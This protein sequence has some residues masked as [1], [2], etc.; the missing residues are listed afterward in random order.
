MHLRVALEAETLAV[1]PQLCELDRQL[2]LLCGDVAEPVAQRL[3]LFVDGAR[4]HPE[5][6]H[7]AVACARR[8]AAEPLRVRTAGLLSVERLHSELEI[9]DGLEL[10]AHARG[11]GRLTLV[12]HG[13]AAPRRVSGLLRGP[14]GLE[15]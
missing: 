1:V 12:R 8:S 11:I 5:L 14:D 9:L 13:S 10:R 3:N 6:L 7:L 15:L 2:A 4:A